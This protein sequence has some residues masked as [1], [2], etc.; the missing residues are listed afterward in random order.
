MLETWDE[1]WDNIYSDEVDAEELIEQENKDERYKCCKNGHYYENEKHACPW[2]GDEDVVE[3]LDVKIPINRIDLYV[4]NP[5][6]GGWVLTTNP[7]VECKS[8]RI[9]KVTVDMVGK[10]KLF[11][12]LDGQNPNP[13]YRSHIKLGNECYEGWQFVYF[14]DEIIDNGLSNILIYDKK[15][16]V[17]EAAKI[18][19][20]EGSE[21]VSILNKVS[22][23]SNLDEKSEITN[24]A[25]RVLEGIVHSKRDKESE[26]LKS[27]LK[28]LSEEP[29]DHPP[30]ENAMC[31]F[32]HFSI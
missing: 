11:Y 12:H 1:I 30:I 29:S 21:A 7:N 24:R 18:L 8:E 9:R 26:E 22:D 25:F 16:T 17:F 15:R 31:Y 2:C 5:Y 23:L 28:D 10:C 20:I 19:H 4:G 27:K 14:C 13:L 3:M 6:G 32:Q